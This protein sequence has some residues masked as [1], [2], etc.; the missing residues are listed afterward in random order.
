MGKAAGSGF[1]EFA[2]LAETRPMASLDAGVLDRLQA[3]ARKSNEV[4]DPVF[5]LDEASG[6]LTAAFQI[7]AS[8]ARYAAFRGSLRFLAMLKQAGVGATVDTLE[9]VETDLHWD[10]PGDLAL[11]H[12]ILR[13]NNTA[14]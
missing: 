4:L 6:S 13:S 3:V 1:L 11:Y 9:H 10:T 7:E 14:S 5:G 12:E 2:Y 8:A